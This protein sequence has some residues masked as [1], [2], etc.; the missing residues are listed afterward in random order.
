MSKFRAWLAPVALLSLALGLRLVSEGVGFVL[1]TP[2]ATLAL[3]V[4]LTVLLGAAL[5]AVL[6]G[7]ARA[8]GMHLPRVLGLVTAL[9]LVSLLLIP[10]RE[11]ELGALFGL[12]PL[13]AFLPAGGS[14]ALLARRS[15]LGFFVALPTFTALAG[16]GL[17]SVGGEPTWLIGGLAV[18]ALLAAGQWNPWRS[19]GLVPVAAFVLA[20]VLLFVW[21][22]GSGAVLACLVG[23]AAALGF[24]PLLAAAT[25][26]ARG[27]AALLVA[28][29]VAVA[30]PLSPYFAHPGLLALLA[31]GFALVTGYLMFPRLFQQFLDVLC[32][33]LARVRARGPGANA[34]PLDGPL[35][36]VCN[37]SAYLDPMWVYKVTPREMIAMMTSVFYD[38]PVVRWLSK[39]GTHAIRVPATTF[40]REAPELQDA[41][42]VLQRG[43][44][45]LVFPEARLRKTEDRLLFPFGQGLWHVLNAVPNARVLTVWIEGGWGSWT[46]HANNANPFKGKPIDFRR[47]IE[48]GMAEPVT[49]APELLADKD[50]FRVWLMDRVLACRAYLDLPVPTVAQAT[51]RDVGQPHQTDTEPG[52]DR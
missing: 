24:V 46:S 15:T 44:C 29:L 20:V 1:L 30:L 22:L 25:A 32:F 21:L 12:L 19:P 52:G 3:P 40:R 48:L 10:P 45:V 18:G 34:I 31:L 11:L 37:H 14:L 50:A 49:V 36:I 33:Y 28:V 16:G 35:V 47:P 17:L 51:G 5:L 7:V 6:P 4:G 38:L 42:R 8:S 43:G 41:I 23:V 27:P 13:L 9:A 26:A 2:A 39:H